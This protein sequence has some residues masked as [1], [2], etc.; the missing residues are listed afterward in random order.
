MKVVILAGGVG[1]R[2]REETEVRPK[3]MVEIG[4]R[5]ILSDIVKRYAHYSFKEFVVALGGGYNAPA[6][7]ADLAGRT[8]CIGLPPRAVLTFREAAGSESLAMKSL[9]QQEMIRRDILTVGGFNICW[10]HGD[11]DVDRTLDACRAS[12]SILS[13]AVKAGDV[14]SRVEGPMIEPVFRR[15]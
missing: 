5:P 12:L 11:G 1:T 13:A 9:F 10:S 6:A 8:E 14:V 7:E 15:P 2:L 3:P 4:R